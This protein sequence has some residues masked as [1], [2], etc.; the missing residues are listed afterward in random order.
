MTKIK[1][2]VLIAYLLV[3]SCTAKPIIYKSGVP[4]LLKKHDILKINF[5]NKNDVIKVLGPTILVS[6]P[7]NDEWA[8]MELEKTK[9]IFANEKIVKNN[10][11]ILKFNSKGLLVDK[12]IYDKNHMTSIDFDSSETL[13]LSIS[14]SLSKKIFSSIKKRMR[15]ETSE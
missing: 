2:V 3:I 13:S 9:N 8:Y 10:I 12:K 15:K 11:L 14:S 6:F 1:T 7:V 4:D 5:S